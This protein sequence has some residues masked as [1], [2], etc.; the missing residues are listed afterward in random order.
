MRWSP[1]PYP[2]RQRYT[3]IMARRS[4]TPIT[5]G[6]GATGEAADLVDTVV[7]QIISG[8]VESAKGYIKT[9]SPSVRSEAAEIARKR[10]TELAL[11]PGE[12]DALKAAVPLLKPTA[13]AGTGKLLLIGGGLLAVYLFTRK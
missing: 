9:F 6:M 4:Y 7:E 1:Y 2:Y 5:R 8:S 12:E 3:P 10:S 13:G 11:E